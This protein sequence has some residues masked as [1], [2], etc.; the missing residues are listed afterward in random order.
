MKRMK[1]EIYKSDEVNYVRGE[2]RIKM[3]IMK[4]FWKLDFCADFTNDEIRE[5]K[6]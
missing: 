2:I 5:K 3:I 1:L 4:V 6:G